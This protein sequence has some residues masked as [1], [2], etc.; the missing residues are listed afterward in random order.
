LRPSPNTTHAFFRA[1]DPMPI[2]AR[3]L[4]L[5]MRPVRRARRAVAS[6]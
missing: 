2:F 1:A 6:S 4:A 3:P 5:L